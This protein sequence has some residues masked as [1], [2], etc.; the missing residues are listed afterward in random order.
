MEK[1]PSVQRVILHPDN[2]LHA[3]FISL[4][5]IRIYFDEYINY[6]IISTIQKLYTHIGY[7]F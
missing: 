4:Q 2:I 6:L 1:N 3:M 7:I 5:K